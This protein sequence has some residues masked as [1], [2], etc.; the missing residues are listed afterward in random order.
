MTA[1]KTGDHRLRAGFPAGWR[2]GDKTGTGERG[3]AND[4]AVAWTPGAPI[5]V[6]SYL[7]GAVSAAA[8]ARDAV[9]AKVAGI[10]AAHFRPGA[11]HG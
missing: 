5:V 1:C 4:I 9:H 6:A 8:A 2:I 10:V 3:T 11:L 7:T